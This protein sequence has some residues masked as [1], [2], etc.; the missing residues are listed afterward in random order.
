M[1]SGDE[2]A[3]KELHE[4]VPQ[5]E[6]AVVKEGFG[7]YNCISMSA[8]GARDAIRE[9]ARRSVSRIG[10]IKPY[11]VPGPVT[12]QIEYT[13]RNS[14]RPTPL[15]APTRRF[16]TT[17]RFDTAATTFS[18]PGGFTASSALPQALIACGR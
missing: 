15:P 14:L 3:A 12:L 17:A 9:A 4:I 16:S 7:R 18:K 5:A 6:V 2:A 1:L 13:T 10:T 8:A 11:V